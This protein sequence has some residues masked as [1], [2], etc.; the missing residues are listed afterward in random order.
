MAEEEDALDMIFGGG[1][2][3]TEHIPAPSVD[4]KVSGKTQ[5]RK[6]KRAQRRQ[7][8]KNRE[9]SSIDTPQYELA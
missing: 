7:R 4:P 8:R 9:A 6:Q 2:E 3:S 1:S 5:T